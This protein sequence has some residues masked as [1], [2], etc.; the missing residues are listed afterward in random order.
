MNKKPLQILSTYTMILLLF[1]SSNNLYAQADEFNVLVFLKNGTSVCGKILENK[2]ERIIKLQTKSGSVFEIKYDE[3][4][5]IKKG[6]STIYLHQNEKEQK[7]LQK[8]NP[9]PSLSKDTTKFTKKPK[10]QVIKS[11]PISS[12]DENVKSNVLLG[13]KVGFFHL[14]ITAGAEDLYGQPAGAF[15]GLELEIPLKA[16]LSILGSFNNFQ[17]STGKVVQKIDSRTFSV[18]PKYHQSWFLFGIKVFLISEGD[19]RPYIGAK[20]GNIDANMETRDYDKN[21]KSSIEGA[22]FRKSSFCYSLYTGFSIQ[23]SK[24]IFAFLELELIGAPLREFKEMGLV[25]GGSLG[26]VC[27]SVGLQLGI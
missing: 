21:N 15:W 22:S 3:V 14:I 10:P 12:E 13:A 2:T 4:E 20:L 11:V 9:S 1:L 7:P 16:N 25:S 19:L 24:T 27:G 8:I 17:S 5:K 26:G 18:E 6:D 23:T